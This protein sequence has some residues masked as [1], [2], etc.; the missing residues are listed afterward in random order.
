MAILID[1][2]NAIEIFCLLI[3]AMALILKGPD[4]PAKW[5]SIFFIYC[6]IAYLSMDFTRPGLVR[7]I[8][9]SGP[10]LLPFSFWVF[11]DGLFSDKPRSF[12]ILLILGILI[13]GIN[14]SLY[15]F[16]IEEASV[17]S[18]GMAVLFVLLAIFEAQKQRKTDLVEGR[19]K[20]R[21]VFTYVVSIL[22]LLTLLSGS[23]LIF[24]HQ[25][26]TAKLIQRS[27]ILIFTSYFLIA[28]VSVRD[29]FFGSYQKKAIVKN[30]ELVD[31][32]Q[33]MVISDNLY[34]KEA[35]T[36]GQ[37]AEFMG[38]QEYKVRQAINQELG[39]KNF[40][41]FI[42]SFRIQE[43]KE[44]F[45]DPAKR[46]MTVIEVAYKVGFNSIRPFNRAFKIVTN[47]T[48]TEYRNSI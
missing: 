47:Q 26:I 16:E 44:V 46:D 34:R 40:T 32:I 1:Y 38:E 42:N 23:G 4:S 43:A 8:I 27:A 9:V 17:I 2:I 33:T 35:L 36:I 21:T 25:Q 39:Y 22:V 19:R 20:I 14:Y 15:F 5:P 13:L 45:S 11:S 30:P 31:K 37:L 7:G 29:V 12:S 10:F 6:V 3:S 28:N 24:S 41:D 18:R 48:P